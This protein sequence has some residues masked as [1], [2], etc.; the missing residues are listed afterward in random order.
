MSEFVGEKYYEHGS[1]C[2]T[3][4]LLTNLG[5]PDAPTAKAVKPYLRQFLSDPRV[6]E[7]P[8]FFWQIILRGIILQIR[9]RRSAENYLKIWTKEGSPLL[10]IAKKQLDLVKKGLQSN[11]PN[12]VVELAMRYGNPSIESALKELQQMQVRRLLVFPLYPQYCAATTASTFDAVTNVLRKWRWIPELRF[13]NSYFEEETYIAALVNSI[14]QFW[15]KNGK[16]QKIV[17][18]YHGIPKKYHTEGDPYHCFCLKTTRLVKECMKLN[19]ED[20]ITTFQSRFGRQ[21]WLQPYTSQTL[22]ELPSK[23]I[24][25]IHI[26]SPGFSAD[27]LETLEE[28]EKENREYF[29]KAGGKEYKYIPCLNDNPLH[30][31]MMMGLI[32]K[33]TQ[34]WKI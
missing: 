12:T 6:I 25:N 34:G 17:F 7:L 20:V 4:I 23:N 29:E 15:H 11:Y 9:P 21:E 19:D 31:S 13:I 18:S 26:I 33:H 14:Q 16:P 5:T 8:R 27:C 1:P 3:G 2:K 30:I 10:Q 22:K 24:K 32:Q 28:L